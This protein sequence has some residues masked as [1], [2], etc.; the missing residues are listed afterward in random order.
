MFYSANEK[1]AN[2]KIEL[3][4][5]EEITKMWIDGKSLSEIHDYLLLEPLNIN[6]IARIC[7]KDISYSLSFLVGNVL[8]IVQEQIADEDLIMLLSILQKQLRYGVSSITEITLCEIV[9]Y[10]RAIVKEIADIIGI[11]DVQGNDIIDYLKYNK[12]S[13]RDLLEMYPSYF[14]SKFDNIVS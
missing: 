7:E 14:L 1:R 10:D 13:I 11:S 8:D 4:E 12:Q 3:R 5:F 6:Q 9:F 2:S